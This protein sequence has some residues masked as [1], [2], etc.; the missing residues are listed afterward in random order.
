MNEHHFSVQV[1]N[2]DDDDDEISTILCMKWT[3][4]FV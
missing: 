1:T 2:D 4:K 3:Y